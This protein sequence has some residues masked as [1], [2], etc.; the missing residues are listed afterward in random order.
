VNPVA[1]NIHEHVNSPQRCG[2]TIDRVLRWLFLV[3]AGI[4]C[5]KFLFPGTSVLGTGWV[6]SMLIVTATCSLIGSLSLE[7]PPQNVLLAAFVMGALGTAVRILESSLSTPFGQLS[8][9]TGARPFFFGV[10]WAVPLLSIVAILVSRGVARVTFQ[11]HRQSSHYGL[12]VM[13]LTILLTAL[14]NV[15]LETFGSRV[16]HYWRWTETNPEFSR[17]GLLLKELAASLITFIT[18]VLV[19]PVLIDKKP[20]PTPPRLYPLAVWTVFNLLFTVG[21]FTAGLWAAAIGCSA[22]VLCGI[23]LLLLNK[24]KEGK[25]KVAE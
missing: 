22:L 21:F 20:V 2:E 23:C 11:T 16:G 7:L 12:W 4:A 19:T 6:E 3:S 14:F 1:K 18:L 10:S 13:G 9:L 5:V 8:F 24:F 15:S 17:A 25:P